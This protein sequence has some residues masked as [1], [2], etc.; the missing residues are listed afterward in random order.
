MGI[1]NYSFSIN[2]FNVAFTDVIQVFSYEVCAVWKLAGASEY[3]RISCVPAELCFTVEQPH[4]E[5]HDH[6]YHRVINTGSDCEKTK[7]PR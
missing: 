7:R 1:S 4:C 6:L 2:P 5:I 3:V